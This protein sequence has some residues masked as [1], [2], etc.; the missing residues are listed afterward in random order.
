M[1][2]VNEQMNA[3]ALKLP[4]FWPEDPA[5]WFR[6]V[7]AQFAT[8]GIVQSLTKYNYVVAALAPD[9]AREIRDL[10]INILADDPY[11]ILKEQLIQRTALTP[12]QR[13]QRLLNLEPL[14]DLKP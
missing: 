10:I 7:E 12:S 5:L 14:G 2:Q 11:G 6:Q 3:V 1:A 13:M 9:T 4:P 8:R